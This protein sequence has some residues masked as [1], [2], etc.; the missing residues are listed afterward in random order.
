M[1]FWV[2]PETYEG[3]E[4]R[5]KLCPLLCIGLTSFGNDRTDRTGCQVALGIVNIRYLLSLLTCFACMWVV[6]IPIHVDDGYENDQ[7]GYIKIGI[8]Y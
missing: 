2:F 7:S 5:N 4:T 8:P 1:I 3:R 6:N